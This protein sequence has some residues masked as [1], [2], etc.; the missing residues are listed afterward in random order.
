MRCKKTRAFFALPLFLGALLSAPPALAQRTAIVPSSREPTGEAKE[1]QGGPKNGRLSL[2]SSMGIPAA[3]ELVGS[4]RTEDRLRGIER[5]EAIGTLE[6]VDAL[7]DAMEQGS[8][9][10]RDPKARLLTVRALS[11]YVERDGARQF[12]VRELSDTAGSEGRGAASP[13]SSLSRS[14]AALALARSG[15]KKALTALSSAI[16]QGGPAGAAAEAALLAYPPAS[17]QDF[18][19]GKKKIVPQLAAFLGQL[20]DLRALE[21]LRATMNE[22]DL[23]GQAAAALA[24]AKLGDESVLDK[25]RPWL[26]RSEP[27]LQRAAATVLATL[28]AADAPQAIGVLLAADATRS[29]GLELAFSAPSPSLARALATVLPTLSPDER[30]KAIAAIGRGGGAEALRQ[31]SQLAK[32]SEH[33]LDAAFALALIP[34]QE[35][36]DVL[37]RV[38]SDAG[39]GASRRLLVRAALMRALA[40]GDRVDGLLDALNS[41]A[42]AKDES[43]RAVGIFGQ[44][45]LSLRAPDELL[46]ERCSVAFRAEGEGEASLWKSAPQKGAKAAGALDCDAVALHAIAK[47]MQA[48]PSKQLGHFSS[49]MNVLSAEAVLGHSL[50]AARAGEILESGLPNSKTVAAGSA[51]L[52]YPDGG[53]LPTALLSA[54]AEQGGPLS[55]LA[56]R[57]LASRDSEVVR[58]SIKRL[59]EGSDPVVRAHVAMGLAHDSEADSVSL[60]VR[61]YR[62]EDDAQVRRAIVRALSQKSEVQRKKTLLLA[63]DLDP[64]PQVR[65]LARSA[66]LGRSLLAPAVPK[67]RTA[68]WITLLPNHAEA[69]NKAFGRTA[70]LIRSDGTALP[71]VADPDGVLLLPGQSPGEVNLDL[72]P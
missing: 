19:E 57:A 22:G 48:L 43:D 35:A 33:G 54:W 70:R 66:L 2:K 15:Q 55:P 5:L 36:S 53:P 72:G 68:V 30:P 56:A 58:A 62:F 3:S 50:S 44:A 59:L 7:L 10:G 69:S 6:A 38:L 37:A 40:L 41:L 17:L 9:I 65:A 20:G 21:R 71:V 61:A 14:T 32:T 64:D 46:K 24:L 31:L 13:L 26:K 34:G 11:K 60:L 49:L 1:A 23:G 47:G 4:D 12:L 29:F 51:L 25:V 8:S 28:K 16:L 45:A 39:S 27:K 18:L 67:D 42:Q 52:A 63:R